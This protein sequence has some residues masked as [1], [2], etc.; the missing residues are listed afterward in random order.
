[1][2][3]AFFDIDGTLTSEHAW[4]GMLDYFQRHNLRRGTHLAYMAVHYPLYFLRRLNLIS[5]GAFRSPWAAH[6][7]WYLRGFTLQQADNLWNWTVEMHLNQHWRPDTR[8]LLDQ[9]RNSGDVVMLVSSGPQSM[10]ER[11]AHELGAQYG[12]G[13]RLEVRNGRYTGRSLKPVCI[14]QYKALMAKE[15]IRSRGLEIDLEASFAYA[16]SVADLSLLELVGHPVA[17]HPDPE[18]RAI[19]EGLGW[20]TIPGKEG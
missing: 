9:H 6:L 2:R 11:I 13:T 14:D 18:L 1:M 7:A 19:A 15:L 10:I 4:K 16:D 17:V 20:R 8:A 5:E 12:I 3:A